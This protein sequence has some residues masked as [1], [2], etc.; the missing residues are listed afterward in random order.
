MRELNK[1][2][3]LADWSDAELLEMMA[4]VHRPLP[5]VQHRKLWEWAIGMLSLKNWEN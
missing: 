3:A 1:I 2:C 4:E 5:V